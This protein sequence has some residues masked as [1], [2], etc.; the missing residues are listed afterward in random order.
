MKPDKEVIV[1]TFALAI[2]WINM[3]LTSKGWNPLPFTETE[4]G[5]AVSVVLAFAATIWSWWKNNSLTREAQMGDNYMRAAKA[6][7]AQEGM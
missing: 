1:R 3:I 6:K 5:E 2:T 4:V 7:H